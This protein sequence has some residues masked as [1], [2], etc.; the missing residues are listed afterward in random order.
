M[1]KSIPRPFIRWLGGKSK[2]TKH[3]LE[4]LPLKFDTYYEP[5]LGGGAVFFELAKQNR[6]KRAVLYDTN[7]EVINAFQVIKT[8]VN[9][10]IK[11]LRSGRYI[12]DRDRYLKIRAEGN[13]GK[14]PIKKAARFIYLNKTCFNGLYRVNQ[15]GEFNAPFGKYTDPVICDKENLLAVS[16]SLRKVRIEER[17]FDKVLKEAKL[18]DVVYFDPPYLPTSKTSNFSSYTKERFDLTDHT[19]LSLVFD[20]LVE[21][22]I[23][24]IASNSWAAQELY[25]NHE[26]I[27]LIG[28]RC[29]GGPTEYRNA[30]EE[31]MVVANCRSV[32]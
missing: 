22:G 27:R 10:L 2:M 29:I 14:S 6:F 18:G 9:R 4:R 3:I 24:T 21:R 26:I 15:K 12:Y 23:S 28:G 16:E 7:P 31:I 25:E 32:S 8:D 30:V 11:E 13:E 20:Q 5:F 1:G 19:L 17:N